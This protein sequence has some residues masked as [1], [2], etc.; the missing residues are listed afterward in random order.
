MKINEKSA[1]ELFERVRYDTAS[2]KTLAWDSKR[3]RYRVQ[4]I[5]HEFRVWCQAIEATGVCDLLFFV[6]QIVEAQ[7]KAGALSD[8]RADEVL[9]CVNQFLEKSD[10]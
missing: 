7:I 3:G 10:V 2:P 4:K 8:K 6:A 5:N 9:T 1:R